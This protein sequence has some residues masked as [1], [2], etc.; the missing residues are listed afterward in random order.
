MPGDGLPHQ[1]M[2]D[3]SMVLSEAWLSWAE[4]EANEDE[5]RDV[6]V[7]RAL[8]GQLREVEDRAF[9]PWLP[10]DH[11]EDYVVYR[12]RALGLIEGRDIRSFSFDQVE[13]PDEFRTV[14]VALL[15]TGDRDAVTLA[16][17]WAFLKS[18][19]WLLS[20]THVSTD[21]FRRRGASVVRFTH[22]F[23]RALAKQVIPKE[24]IPDG[25]TPRFLAKVGAKWV[26]WGT[27]TT[28]GGVGGGMGGTLIAGPIGGLAG[29]SGGAW[30]VGAVAQ[31]ALLEWD[32]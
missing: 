26:V 9:F 7:S 27:A 16:D 22:R 31:A 21:A 19:S 29:G 11:Q 18:Q 32:P 30:V 5:I 4:E 3:P 25:F 15:E 17:E 24:N 13:L 28:A 14:L 12:E 6:V 23:T 20:A 2:V 10:E 8:L 1:Y